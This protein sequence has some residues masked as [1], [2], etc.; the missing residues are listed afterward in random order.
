MLYITQ[1][2]LWCIFYNI[3]QELSTFFSLSTLNSLMPSRDR[4]GS[5]QPDWN[6]EAGAECRHLPGS[7]AGQGSSLGCG[8]GSSSPLQGGE[9][10]Q[11]GVCG[12]GDH[13][14]QAS[15]PCRGVPLHL[16]HPSPTPGRRWQSV[17]THP[18]VPP[19][20]HILPADNPWHNH[21]QLLHLI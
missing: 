21:E 15:L 8:E 7:E 11:A 16:P 3:A 5:E 10:H 12:S 14:V 2:C 20:V 17:L 18:H 13:C 4:E 1:V 6:R 19:G 9:A